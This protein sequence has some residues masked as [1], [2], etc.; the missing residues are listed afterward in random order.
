MTE[1]MT[2][3][4][5]F[6]TADRLLMSGIQPT[7]ELIAQSLS[8]STDEVQ[9]ILSGWWAQAPQRL[10]LAV[11]KIVVPEVPDALAKSFA[12][13]W[14]QAIQEANALYQQEQRHQ[15]VGV[16]E[17]KR[18]ADEHLQES[19]SRLVELEDRLRNSQAEKEELVSQIKG[20]EAEVNVLKT[21]L[22]SE[23]SQRKQEEK[24]RMNVEQELNHLRKT[25]D[26]SKRTFDQRIKDEQRH[27]LDA[28]SKA[29]ADVRYY[30]GALE[31]LR[32]DVGK[33]ESALTKNIHDLQAEQARKDAKAEAQKTQ[34]KSLEE[35]LK[36]IKLN[37]SGQSRD[38]SKINNQLLSESNKNK[39][40]EDK[41]KE[42]EEELKKARQKQVTLATEHSRREAAL[43]NQYKEK[44][45]E[46]VRTL[47]K[48]TSLEKRI[49]TQD[50]E[51]R[52]L[53]SRL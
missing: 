10:S 27:T 8:V 46:L 13:I 17:L 14:Q 38:L 48:I 6:T 30:R 19:K 15:S 49:V 42:I 25:H 26:D 50:E 36:N 47:A 1:R 28:I 18:E 3:E 11:P 4:K 31:K 23:T 16:D 34:I 53:N 33:K 44:E 22:A 41:L 2:D 29:D 32:D 12:V 35:E 45:E 39:R 9:E 24:A 21:N 37:A 43:R 20:L 51:V 40:L 5:I 7:A 52:R